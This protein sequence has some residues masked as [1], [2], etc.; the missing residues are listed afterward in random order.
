MQLIMTIIFFLNSGYQTVA[1]SKMNITLALYSLIG[2]YN[3]KRKTLWKSKVILN[4]SKADCTCIDFLINFP[5]K[6]Q[7][8]IAKWSVWDH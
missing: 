6:H 3:K 8:C 1:I 5:H 7:N 4:F 2:K